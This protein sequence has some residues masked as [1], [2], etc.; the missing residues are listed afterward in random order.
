[1][2]HI[3]LTYLKNWIDDIQH[4][5]AS[6]G[7]LAVSEDR[8]QRWIVQIMLH[9]KQDVAVGSQTYVTEIQNMVNELQSQNRHWS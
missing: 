4:A 7:I 3:Q 8:L 1:M 5:C 2:N 6:K 9:H